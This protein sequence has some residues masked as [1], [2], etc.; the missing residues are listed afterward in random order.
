NLLP[1]FDGIE[2]VAGGRLER[3][4]RLAHRADPNALNGV[5][6]E[7]LVD[8]GAQLCEHSPW[9]TNQVL[10]AD[11]AVVAAKLAPLVPP[12]VH[13]PLPEHAAHHEVVPLVP[14]QRIDPALLGKGKRDVTAVPD[15]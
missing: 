3:G 15:D 10:E 2:R 5:V 14:G 7:R 12:L 1:A 11:L 8:E 9:I 6:I 13:H 4:V